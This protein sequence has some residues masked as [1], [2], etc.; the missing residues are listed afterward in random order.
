MSS[1]SVSKNDIELLENKIQVLEKQ[2]SKIKH[3]HEQVITDNSSQ[4]QDYQYYS[5]LKRKADS[6]MSTKNYKT[7]LQNDN[8]VFLDSNMEMCEQDIITK[9]SAQK[10]S[11]GMAAF[12]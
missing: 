2:I 9:S 11:R 4:Q 7:P 12:K 6:S 1:A 10:Y 8:L 3:K 5:S